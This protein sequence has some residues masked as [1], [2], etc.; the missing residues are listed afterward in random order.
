M[1]QKEGFMSDLVAAEQVPDFLAQVAGDVTGLEAVDDSCISMPFLKLAQALTDGIG[2]VDGLAAGS[3]YCKALGKVYGKTLRVIPLKFYRNYNEWSGEGREAKLV[4]T[5]TLV[6]FKNM[7]GSCTKDGEGRIRTAGGNRL[8][9]TRN[10]LVLNADKLDDGIMLLSFQSS[11]IPASRSWL[12]SLVNMRMGG[13]SLPMYAKI[14]ELSASLEKGD[15]G[16]YY[17]MAAPRDCGFI[18]AD[19]ATPV[20]SAFNGVQQIEDKDIK[21]DDDIKF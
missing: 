19:I 21:A 13:K 2:E 4:A 6:D 12:T 9:D 18:K 16:T 15:K 5:H 1:G 11:A 7:E 3:F 8:V 14:W 10:F 17:K 20:M